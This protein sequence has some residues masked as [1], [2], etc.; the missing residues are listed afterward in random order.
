MKKLFSL[1]LAALMLLLPVLSLAET[2]EVHFW[3]GYYTD[4]STGLLSFIRLNEDGTYYGKFFDGSRMEAGIWELVDVATDYAVDADGDGFADED[5]Q[6]L[7]HAVSVQSIAFTPYST[8]VTQYVA[9]VDDVLCNMTLAGLAGNRFLKHISD[10]PYNPDVDEVAIQLYVFYANND[11]GATFI[12]NHNGTFEDCTG[13]Y[14]EE[15]SWKMTGA[16]EYELSYDFG[17]GSLKVDANGKTAVLQPAEGE[18]LE[19]KDDWHE[20]QGVAKVMTLRADEVTVEELPMP[21]SVRLD[22]TSDGNIKLY[23]EIAQLG[24]DLL[25]D[26]GTFEVNAAMQPTFHFEKAGDIAGTPDYENA[27]ENGI[28]FVLPYSAS[29]APEFNGVETPMTLEAE[30]NGMYNPNAQPAQV[31]MSLSAEQVTAEGLP[32]PVDLLV[33]MY[34]DGKAVLLVQ[35]VQMGLDLQADQGTW[36]MNEAMQFPFV[37]ETLGEVMGMP[38]YT[39]ATGTS[40]DVDLPVNGTV[41]IEFD[42]NEMPLTFDASVHGTFSIQ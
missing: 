26:Q 14:M 31:I 33:N 25:A 37:F 4:T 7:E 18:A 23:V 6:Q 21:V 41:N 36:T 35:V 9:Y 1:T 15:G 24:V 10:Y 17:A 11:V 29:V 5:E 27:N 40:I 2:A 42:G 22:G 39:S 38:D 12:L 8:G 30:L 32:M 13:E 34:D 28:G 3:D 19:V 16:G 20:N